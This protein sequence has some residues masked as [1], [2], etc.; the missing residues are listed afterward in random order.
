MQEHYHGNPVPGGSGG[1]SKYPLN[2]LSPTSTWHW[3][4]NTT[5]TSRTQETGGGDSQNLQPYVTTFT[6]IKT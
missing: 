2:Q 1:Y 5:A 4:V 3:D 6:I